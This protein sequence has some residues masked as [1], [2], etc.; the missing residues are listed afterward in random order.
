[1]SLSEDDIIRIMRDSGA[2]SALDINEEDVRDGHHRVDEVLS[3]M[4]LAHEL[5]LK[6]GEQT[7]AAVAITVE[8]WLKRHRDRHA[9]PPDS[10]YAHPPVWHWTDE[11]LNDLRDHVDTGTPL[12]E[13]VAGPHPEED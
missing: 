12:T 11:L 5:G 2:M 10:P 9:E 8:T 1:M 13:P 3:A 6:R 7:P 4:K